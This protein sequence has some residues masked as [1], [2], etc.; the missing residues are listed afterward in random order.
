MRKRA[1]PKNLCYS[2]DQLTFARND[3]NRT[4]SARNLSAITNF[5]DALTRQKFERG[6]IGVALEKLFQNLIKH[7]NVICSASEERH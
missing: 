2:A 6:G 1:R 7:G 4:T 5:E 3:L